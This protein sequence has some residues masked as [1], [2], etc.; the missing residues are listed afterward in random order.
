VRVIVGRVARYKLAVVSDEGII[1]LC[2]TSGVIVSDGYLA[3]ILEGVIVLCG[4]VGMVVCDVL[5]D[6]CC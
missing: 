2:V 6:M 5:C 1:A 3:A 4:T